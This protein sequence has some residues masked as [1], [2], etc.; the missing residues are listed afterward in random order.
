MRDYG[1]NNFQEWKRRF[2]K[3]LLQASIGRQQILHSERKFGCNVTATMAVQLL[4]VYIT[5][6]SR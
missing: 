1:Y 3:I 2:L 4:K 5:A 6:T